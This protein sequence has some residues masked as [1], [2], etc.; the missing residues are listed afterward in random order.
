MIRLI[1]KDKTAED[2]KSE[3]G[4]FL[5]RNTMAYR[6]PESKA[7]RFPTIPLVVRLSKKKNRIP[8]KENNA[9]STDTRS[10]LFFQKI[11]SIRMI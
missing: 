7:R 4:I 3:F 11:Q 10:G 5:I 9:V 1:A 8:M 6:R 2:S